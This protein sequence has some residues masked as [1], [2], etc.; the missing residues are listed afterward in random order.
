MI[1]LNATDPCINPVTAAWRKVDIAQNRFDNADTPA[2]AEAAALEL[3]AAVVLFVEIYQRAK[4][5]A[6]GA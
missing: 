2:R 1:Q 5:E 4:A 3:Q 6:K